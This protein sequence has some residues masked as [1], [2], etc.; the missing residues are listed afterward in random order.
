MFNLKS[1]WYLSLFVFLFSYK[2]EVK[3]VVKPEYQRNIEV[4][5]ESGFYCRFT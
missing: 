2:Y 3:V 1:K 5:K 4:F